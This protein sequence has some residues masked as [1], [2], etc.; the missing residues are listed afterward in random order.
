[1]L[2]KTLLALVP[3]ILL[4]ATTFAEDDF[5]KELSTIKVDSIVDASIS[6][7]DGSLDNLDVDGLSKNASAETG[8][9][10]IEACFRRFGY[11]RHCGFGYGY[12]YRHCYQP[13]FNYYQ[14][15]YCYRPVY[16]TYHCVPV[17]TNYWGCY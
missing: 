5:L 11:R 6:I 15:L 13:C 17:I 12:G 10:A 1:M 7:D 14:P 16:Y 9:E 3:M 8:D 4:T 2:K